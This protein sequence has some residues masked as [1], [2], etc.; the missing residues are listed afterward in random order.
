LKIE[1]DFPKESVSTMRENAAKKARRTVIGRTL[2]GRATFKT[3]LDCLKLHLP[4]PP[5]STTLF[6]RGYFEILFENEEGAK[7]TRRLIAVEWNDLRLSFS[8]YI[9]NFDASSQGAE[10]QLTLAIKVQFFDVHEQFRNTKA[11]TIMANKIGEVLEI[12]PAESYIKRPAGSLITIELKDISKLPGYIRIPSMAEG[13]GT[14]DMIKQRILYSGL[15]NQCRK[16]KRFGHHARSCT[17]NR[18]KPWEGAPSSVG[19][20]STSAPV[21]RQSDGGAPY[22][23]Q[24]QGSRLPRSQ[25]GESTQAHNRMNL[26][27]SEARN[28]LEH[29]TESNIDNRS[30]KPPR[31][32]SQPKSSS[33]AEALGSSKADYVM[34]E[35]ASFLE[36]KPISIDQEL[37]KQLEIIRE[38]KAKPNFGF[39]NAGSP[40]STQL[41]ISTNPFAALEVDNPEAEEGKENLGELKE[42]WSFQ[43]RKKHTPRITSLRQALPQ[44]PTPSLG[45][46]V[47]PGGR[48]KRMH[49]DVHYSYFTS[50]GISSPPGQEHARARI[51][52][53]LSREKNAQIELLIFA[54]NNALPGLQLSI[55]I[56]GSLEE[57]WTHA[58]ALEDITQSI[59]SEFEDKI[60]RFSLN[61]KD[62]FSLEWSWQEDKN[63]GGWACT[64]L[65]HISIGSSAISVQNKKHLHWR[66]SNS[67][68]NM[69]N[70]RVCEPGSQP[71][72]EVWP[73]QHRMSSAH[74]RICQ[75]N[76][77]SPSY[78]KEKV[79]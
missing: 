4:A 34:T 11:L 20:P 14:D 38:S 57:E 28:Q 71:P 33:N 36:L 24:D 32:N 58:S 13:I 16:C 2:G 7:A 31:A 1:A 68:T 65:A 51:W 12:E 44:T 29:P 77:I 27:H 72:L 41:V 26:V 6:T 21:R 62:C 40:L 8:R 52:P 46:D 56:T 63:R 67:L 17:T 75:P 37:S 18:N 60:L 78:Q 9:P 5:V 22:P 42:S 59:E 35:Q 15:S 25:K 19:P 10:A 48:R 3:L 54:K 79:H 55:R 74:E 73:R 49:L 47:T 45:H 30:D 64:I 50:L 70:D 39:Q 61:L 43:G 69:N 76:G 53:I 23:K 66:T